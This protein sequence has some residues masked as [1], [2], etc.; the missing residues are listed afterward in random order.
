MVT[1]KRKSRSPQQ[2]SSHQ[3]RKKSQNE[4]AENIQTNN[5]EDIN[6]ETYGCLTTTQPKNPKSPLKK[7]S[8]RKR[9]KEETKAINQNEV[10]IATAISAAR[11]IS[12]MESSGTKETAT[13][14]TK[15]SETPQSGNEETTV[16]KDDKR[17]DLEKTFQVPIITKNF[18]ENIKKKKDNDLTKSQDF[19]KKG[20]PT[21]HKS[22][23]RK[24]FLK[25]DKPKQPSNPKRLQKITPKTNLGN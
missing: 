13:D 3:K 11:E 10:E 14:K 16:K 19:I 21:R 24:D 22:L 12:D 2:G 20:N 6:L 18:D 9:D 1:E 8:E 7:M 17:Q 5:F 23:D 4:Q 15:H 25:T